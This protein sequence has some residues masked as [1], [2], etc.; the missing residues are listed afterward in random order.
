M[1]QRKKVLLQIRMMP[2]HCLRYCVKPMTCSQA[3][4]WHLSVIFMGSCE[5]E[6]ADT[7]SPRHNDTP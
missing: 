3:G 7:I 5:V 6:A 2:R 1:M 4:S